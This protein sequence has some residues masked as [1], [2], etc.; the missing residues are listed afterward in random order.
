MTGR[1]QQPTTT[2]SIHLCGPTGREEAAVSRLHRTRSFWKA[3]NSLNV[4]LVKTDRLLNC[5]VNHTV[6]SQCCQTLVLHRITEQKQRHKHNLHGRNIMTTF[7]PPHHKT[8][9]SAKG[10]DSILVTSGS[11]IHILCEENEDVDLC[12]RTTVLN[13][14][15]HEQSTFVRRW[16]F[17]HE[18][19]DHPESSSSSLH[20]KVQKSDRTRKSKT[21]RCSSNKNWVTLSSQPERLSEGS[22]WAAE[23][24]TLCSGSLTLL[25]SN[26]KSYKR[27][28]FRDVT[29]WTSG[30]CRASLT[31]FTHIS[32]GCPN[33][34]TRLFM[35][36]NWFPVRHWTGMNTVNTETLERLSQ[37]GATRR[38]SPSSHPIRTRVWFQFPSFQSDWSFERHHLCPSLPA[39]V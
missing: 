33:F 31:C 8:S 18:P 10:F 38:R 11:K 39:V 21:G 12:S 30:L 25:I 20:A 23:C 36:Q 34:C 19:A 26:L 14:P 7:M 16:R 32:L 4:M 5:S 9:R 22:F 27:R 17:G 3:E 2:E 29:S 37:W 24:H 35:L 15:R 6:L 1:R 28:N 13:T